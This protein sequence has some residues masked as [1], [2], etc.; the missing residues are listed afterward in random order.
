MTRLLSILGCYKYFLKFSSYRHSH[1]CWIFI[2]FFSIPFL[3]WTVFKAILW[4]NINNCKSKRNKKYNKE[5]WLRKV[6]T[7]FLHILIFFQVKQYQMFH[8]N[9]KSNCSVTCQRIQTLWEKKATA[10]KGESRLE[11]R[12]YACVSVLYVSVHYA[13]S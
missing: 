12:R 11:V 2:I 1:I 7:F 3:Y 5:I 9:F 8:R 4:K 10:P 6:L 13:L